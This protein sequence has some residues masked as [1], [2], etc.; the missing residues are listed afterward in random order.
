MSLYYVIKSCLLDFK[1][2][3]AFFCRYI[4]V[5][6]FIFTFVSRI[7]IHN[8]FFQL[9]KNSFF[10]SSRWLIFFYHNVTRIEDILQIIEY[11][12]RVSLYY[13]FFFFFFNVLYHLL[14]VYLNN[15][16]FYFFNQ[17]KKKSYFS[18]I[19]INGLTRKSLTNVK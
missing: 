19:E 12:L 18:T 5:F 1:I 16:F 13:P 6:I 3:I 8:F 2:L 15:L 10:A 11:A 17:L 4:Y 14:M 9:A 7:Q